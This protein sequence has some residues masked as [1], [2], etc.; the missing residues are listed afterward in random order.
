MY[1]L[2]GSTLTSLGN[3]H[4]LTEE[5]VSGQ[6]SN[7]VKFYRVGHN[8]SATDAS[9]DSGYDGTFYAQ[10]TSDKNKQAAIKIHFVSSRVSWAHN[11]AD[12]INIHQNGTD[13]NTWAYFDTKDA[14]GIY[15]QNSFTLTIYSPAGV[16]FNAGSS[17]IDDKFT[18]VANSESTSGY[19]IADVF[20]FTLKSTTTMSGGGASDPL[21]KI[22]FSSKDGN[23]FFDFYFDCYNYVPILTGCWGTRVTQPYGQKKSF[24]ICKSNVYTSLWTAKKNGNNINAFMTNGWRYPMR[25]DLMWLVTN[26]LYWDDGGGHTSGVVSPNLDILCTSSDY[27]IQTNEE[28]SNPTYHYIFY[29]NTNGSLNQ[30][31]QGHAY[32]DTKFYLHCIHD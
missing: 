28:V 27:V 8:T 30:W 14:R 26:D 4:N 25:P 22:Y 29:Y 31:H 5:N 17:S 23:N 16:T 15:N 19:Y 21:G 6:T 32:T 9:Y 12:G 3:W 20:T 11:R 10:N 7:C 2:G 13:A 1:S 18:V 24:F